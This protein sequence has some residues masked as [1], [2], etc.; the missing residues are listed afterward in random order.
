MKTANT[1]FSIEPYYESSDNRFSWSST[2]VTKYKVV[3][4]NGFT[5]FYGTWME[6]K[7]WITN[8]KDK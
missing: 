5:C 8:I 7:E 1:K 2:A 4:N 3:D 6:C